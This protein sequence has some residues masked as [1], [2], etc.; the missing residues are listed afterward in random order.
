MIVMTHKNIIIY[1]IM[2]FPFSIYYISRLCAT[3]VSFFLVGSSG[4][5][6]VDDED[7]VD[8]DSQ[9]EEGD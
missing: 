7:E 1:T 4:M 8:D 3:R 5:G 9:G 2:K 6:A